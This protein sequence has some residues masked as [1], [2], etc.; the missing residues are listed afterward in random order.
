MPNNRL[1]ITRRD[2]LNGLSLGVAAG[3][4]LAPLELLAM[5]R[6]SAAH[7]PPALTGMR[8]SHPGSFEVAHARSRGGARWPAPDAQ[9]A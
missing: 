3:S 9:T 7:Y 4:S 6:G 2:F 5:Q 8:G 1:R